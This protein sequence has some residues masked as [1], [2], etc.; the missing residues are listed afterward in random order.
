MREKDKGGGRVYEKINQEKAT[1]Q[2]KKNVKV[3]NATGKDVL[4][5]PGLK[6]VTHQDA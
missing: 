4:V 5:F 1:K 2:T 6:Y 3:K